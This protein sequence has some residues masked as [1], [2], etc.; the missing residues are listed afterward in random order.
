MDP[1]VNSITIEM[2]D[3]NQAARDGPAVESIL[4]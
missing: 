2:K 3:E 1:V 4:A